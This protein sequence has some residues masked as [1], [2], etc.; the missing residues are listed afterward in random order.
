[1][2]KKLCVAASQTGCGSV[3]VLPPLRAA[4]CDASKQK[5]CQVVKYACM[6][7]VVSIT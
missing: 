6:I 2:F 4:C 5:Q 1:M 7:N 3:R